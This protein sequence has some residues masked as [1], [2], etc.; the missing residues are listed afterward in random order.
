M[1]PQG[2]KSH[3]EMDILR[4]AAMPEPLRGNEPGTFA[5]DTLSRRLPGIARRVLQER[6][7]HVD[8]RR[9][10]EE[11]IQDMPHGR[12]RPLQDP[13]AP[14][15]ALWA[16]WLTPYLGQSWLDAPWFAAEVYFFRRILE[17]TGYFQDSPGR[18]VDPYQAQKRAG[19]EAALKPLATVCAA[20]NAERLSLSESAL[21]ATLTRLLRTVVW[22]N[23]AD[24]SL[25]PAGAIKAGDPP[26]H[27]DAELIAAHLLADDSPVVSRFLL[28]RKSQRTRV[29]FILDN[30]G[31]EL[32]YD[33]LLTNFLLEHDLAQVVVYHAKPFPTYVSDVTVP[34]VEQMLDFL[35][36]NGDADLRS[37]ASRL[38][39][40]MKEDRLRVQSEYF[41]TSP[42]AGW[43]A[44]M[45][46][47]RELAQA[48]LIVS[49]GDANYRRWLGDRHWP[50]TTPFSAVLAYR[51][52]PL[53]A[54]RVNKAELIV[55][56][57]PGKQEEMDAAHPGWLS[58][59]QWGVIQF[60]E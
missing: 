14:D 4:P 49:K 59:G 23:Q 7:W 34:E 6:D 41:W 47:R 32:G 27:P 33:L 30:T 31:L 17:A 11:L 2:K 1:K 43:E 36:Q 15:E 20:L 48:D 40:Q 26:N 19:L 5:E 29:D 56:L 22:G 25:W 57:P 10:L 35:L 51:P 45:D 12:L 54:L 42:L 60:A 50:F 58:N 13:G 8:A 53:L 44:P 18:G 37:L 9:R 39:Q 46:L 55:G 24:L 28:Q 38:D 16:E 52:A 21:D 3:T